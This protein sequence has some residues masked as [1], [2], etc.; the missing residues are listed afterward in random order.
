ML[1]PG[2]HGNSGEY[3]YGFQ[4]QEKDD[5]LKGEGNSVNFSLRLYDP[6]LGKFLKSDPLEPVLP[7]NSPYSFAENDV[8]RSI[9]LEGAERKVVIHW[10]DG[11]YGDGSPKIVK[12]A[13]DIDRSVKYK[14]PNGQVFAKTEVFY[15]MRDGGFVQAEDMYEVINS[16]SPKPSAN[17]DYSQDVIPGKITDDVAYAGFNPIKHYKNISRDLNAPDNYQTLEDLGGVEA[18]MAITG[19][20]TNFRGGAWV[21]E[22][23]KGWSIFSK[24]YQK[25]IAGTDGIAFKFNGVKFDGA[26]GSTL[27]DAK[28]KYSFLLK[29]GWAQEG[30]L[31]QARRQLNAAKNIKGAKIEWHFAEKDAA[32]VV[33]MLFRKEGVKGIDVYHTPIK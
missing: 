14:G 27:L 30:L 29:K 20:S 23:N 1:Q 12:T 3:R 22:S 25:Q 6:R 18:S 28:G 8:V 2:R 16:T 10:V 4:G 11:V 21:A 13:V 31:K 26:R 32:D 33:K 19:F 9:D 7:W 5:D 15:A 17:Y 24:K